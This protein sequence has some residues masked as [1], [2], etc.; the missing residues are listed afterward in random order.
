[1][2]ETNPEVVDDTEH[3]QI[4]CSGDSETD[5]K[6]SEKSDWM[7]KRAKLSHSWEKKYFCLKNTSLYYGD[8]ES[9]VTVK[10]GFQCML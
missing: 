10:V 1:M 9:S 2:A 6:L 5:I 8:T 3:K 7:Y 4:N